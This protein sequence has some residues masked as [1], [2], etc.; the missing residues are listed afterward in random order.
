MCAL[1]DCSVA[2]GAMDNT[3]R[4]FDTSGDCM[5]LAGHQRQSGVDGVLSVAF[6]SDLVSSARDGQ[7][8]VWD[9]Q[10]RAPKRKLLGHGTGAHSEGT[11]VLSISSVAFTATGL[12]ISSGWDKTARLWQEDG[13]C[14][15]LVGHDIA[16][17]SVCSLRNELASG[18]GD[19]TIRL[20]RTAD[21]V[22]VR[23]VGPLGAPVRSMCSTGNDSFAS[24][25]NDGMLRTWTSAGDKVGEVKASSQYLYAVAFSAS[26]GE[27][28]TGGEEGVLK[29]WSVRDLRLLQTVGHLSEIFGIAV[30]PNGD[31]AVACGDGSCLIWSQD[32]R[33]HAKPL[34]I[35]EFEERLG[36]VQA[37]RVQETATPASGSFEFNYPVSL[38]NGGRSMTISWNR[39]DEVEQIATRFLVQNNLP[40]SHLQDVIGFVRQAQSQAQ[41]G[42]TTSGGAPCGGF[43]FSYPVEV[44]DGRRLTLQ[45]NRGDAPDR[46][47]AAFALQHSIPSAEIGDIV[48]FICQASGQAQPAPALSVAQAPGPEQQAAMVRLVTDMGFGEA[49][50]RQAL[51]ATGWIGAD[52]AVSRLLG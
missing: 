14:L 27:L 26:R 13:S 46:V 45:W 44:M 33:R 17:N 35:K 20:W 43:D 2:T 37:A 38:G 28:L 1:P 48:N 52:V 22:C 5:V 16:V 30:C 15:T 24:V 4:V 19:G 34:I 31:V 36:A 42:Q 40:Q 23:T 21:G 12:V 8:L 25:G 9:L 47:A 3:V 18:S 49:Q 51:E 6:G 11:N 32:V 7:I 29:A 10:A 50:A 39:G 41:S